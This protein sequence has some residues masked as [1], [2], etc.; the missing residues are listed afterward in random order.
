M[1]DFGITN[2]TLGT[3]TVSIYMFGLVC[4]PLVIA[5]LSELYGRLPIY[6]T[7]N[8]VFLGFTIGCAKST[9]APMFMVF[10]FIAGCAGSV[11]LAVG[12][13]TIADIMKEEERGIAMGLYAMGPSM[14][15][16]LGP[17]VGGF[18][19]QNIGWRWTF[20]VLAIAVCS[21]FFLSFLS[22][23]IRSFLCSNDNVYIAAR[24]CFRHQSCL[25]T[26]NISKST[27]KT[28]PA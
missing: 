12:G 17:L 7:G 15:P 16:A 10:R 20:W 18:V 14:G 5:P 26:R 1:K 6:H 22:L 8:L 9:N 25:P 21:L 2:T 11:P 24:H 4:G 13:G 27:L 23:L 19:A 28:D 3:F